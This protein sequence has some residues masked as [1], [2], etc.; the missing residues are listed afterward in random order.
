MDYRR[1]IGDELMNYVAAYLTTAQPNQDGDYYQ[2]VFVPDF[3]QCSL[4]ITKEPI[5][6]ELVGKGAKF[7]W[8]KQEWYA[9]G[10]DENQSLKEQIEELR[11]KVDELTGSKEEPAE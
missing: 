7:D 1:Y 4:P 3:V 8:S 11:H 6:T 2:T 9:V 5:P 10:T